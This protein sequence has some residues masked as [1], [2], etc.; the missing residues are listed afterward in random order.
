MSKIKVVVDYYDIQTD[1][2]ENEHRD[3][4]CIL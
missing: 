2:L 1:L 4:S 3:M